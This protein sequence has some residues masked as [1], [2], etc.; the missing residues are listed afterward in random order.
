MTSTH[1][2]H[3]ELRETAALYALGALAPSDAT[4]YEGHLASCQEC[5]AEVDSLRSAVTALASAVPQVDPRPELRVRVLA[6]VVARTSAYTPPPRAAGQWT[7]WLAVAP[8]L[9][10]AHGLGGC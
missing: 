1:T 4:E 8:S 6:S 10:L 3:D 9:V 2:D 7:A 5:A